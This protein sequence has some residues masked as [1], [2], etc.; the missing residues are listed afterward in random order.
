MRVGAFILGLLS[1]AP[2][3]MAERGC[4]ISRTGSVGE[5]IATV[6]GEERLVGWVV[7]AK[8]NEGIETAHF[9]RPGLLIDFEQQRNGQF[10]VAGALV[11]VTRIADKDRGQAPAEFQVQ[12][13]LNGGV[14]SWGVK[15]TAKGEAELAKRLDA[16][17]PGELE[18]LVTVGGDVV[19]SAQFDLSKRAEA[20]WLGRAAL[21]QCVAGQP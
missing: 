4:E 17:W 19:A 10:V 12:A 21:G 6:D 13:K 8:A 9:S 1:L 3:A 5:V 16:R 11:T 18:L 2:S 15:D 7:E 14:L 20:E